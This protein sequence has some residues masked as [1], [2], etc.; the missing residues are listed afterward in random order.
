[1]IIFNIPLMAATQLLPLCQAEVESSNF[2]VYAWE[3][4]KATF[5]RT[6]IT[7]DRYK[8]FLEGIGNT[9][10]ITFGALLV[11]VIIGVAVAIVKVYYHQT[12]PFKFWESVG[13]FLRTGKPVFLKQALLKLLDV[14]INWYLTIF[15]G[16]PVVVQVMI[17]AFVILPTFNSVLVAVIGFGI[18]SGAYVSEIVRAGIMAVD[19]G[20]TEAGRSLGLSAAATMRFIVLPQA[21]KNV[22]PALSN[23]L[24]ALLK[25]TS[26]AGYVAVQDVTKAA[27]LVR[28]RTFDPFFPL[29][30]VACFYL[31]C[32]MLLTFFQK[33]LEKNLQASDRK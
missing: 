31:A 21:F 20:Q 15:R 19:K 9:M 22:L 13:L 14:I 11:G 7:D 25:E 12:G 18:N 26:I 3:A 8:L 24:I 6:F 29:L 23:E 1:M 17:W 32:V 16:T 4:F 5:T 28:S 10:K 30:S 2:L 33:K 27:A